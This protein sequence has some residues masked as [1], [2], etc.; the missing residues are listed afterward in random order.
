[1]VSVV[2]PGGSNKSIYIGEFWPIIHKNKKKYDALQDA[3][4]QTVTVVQMVTIL[5]IVW[6]Y[7]CPMDEHCNRDGNHNSNDDNCKGR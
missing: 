6:E 1:M 2:V 4:S 7:H 3:Q 5:G